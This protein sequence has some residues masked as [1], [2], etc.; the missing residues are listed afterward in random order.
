MRGC[1]SSTFGTFSRFEIRLRAVSEQSPS[2]IFKVP[3]VLEKDDVQ[4]GVE[5]CGDREGL[6]LASLQE[7]TQTL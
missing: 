4:L 1:C 2:D 3:S 6:S 5:Q 7:D